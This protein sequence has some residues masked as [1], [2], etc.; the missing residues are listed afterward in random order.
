MVINKAIQPNQNDAEGIVW[1]G[2][3][4]IVAVLYTQISLATSVILAKEES[5]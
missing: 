5:S 4:K 3:A 2:S 1:V